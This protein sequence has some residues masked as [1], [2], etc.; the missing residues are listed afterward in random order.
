M[1]NLKKTMNE[2]WSWTK[3]EQLK[4]TMKFC[5]FEN[6]KKK[7]KFSEC[8]NLKNERLPSMFLWIWRTDER[9]FRVTSNVYVNLKNKHR[10]RV[11]SEWFGR[12]NRE[13]ECEI[14][15]EWD[16]SWVK[17]MSKGERAKW[18]ESDECVRDI[19]KLIIK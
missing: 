4:K 16:R 14:A 6:L 10:F 7:T 1:L 9:G 18:R 12:F 3:L 19:D 15:N 13:F 2:A 17:R 11:R 8:E 5:E